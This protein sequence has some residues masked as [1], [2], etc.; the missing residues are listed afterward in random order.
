[1]LFEE[2]DLIIDAQSWLVFDSSITNVW[3]VLQLFLILRYLRWNGRPVDDRSRAFVAYEFRASL[4][5]WGSPYY[6]TWTTITFYGFVERAL[7]TLRVGH[8]LCCFL[9]FWSLSKASSFYR[10]RFCDRIRDIELVVMRCC[11][12]VCFN[13][14]RVVAGVERHG[15]C[16]IDA[17]TMQK[18]VSRLGFVRKSAGFSI[19]ISC[20]F[21]LMSLFESF[22]TALSI[23]SCFRWL[24]LGLFFRLAICK[25]HDKV[26]T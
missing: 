20:T 13:D 21:L 25:G 9:N 12:F 7:K 26:K 24:L 10:Q 22:L 6:S 15:L 23:R 2:G 5:Y 17:F 1:M 11:H 18:F 4:A 19:T 16:K 8:F 3:W 14:V